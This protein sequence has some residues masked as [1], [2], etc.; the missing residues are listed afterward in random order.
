MYKGGNLPPLLVLPTATPPVL[1]LPE[2][3]GGTGDVPEVT[4]G[5]TFRSCSRT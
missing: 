4:E 2:I 3:E 1:T 5:L